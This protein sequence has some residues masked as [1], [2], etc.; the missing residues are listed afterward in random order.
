MKTTYSALIRKVTRQDK[1]NP[2]SAVKD[3]HIIDDFRI[4]FAIFSNIQIFMCGI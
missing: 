1:A 4:F 3:L 2:H